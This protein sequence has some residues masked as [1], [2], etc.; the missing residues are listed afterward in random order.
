LSQNSEPEPGVW[1]LRT[2]GPTRAGR[3]SR[4]EVRNEIR[5][6]RGQGGVVL[7]LYARQFEGKALGDNDFVVSADYAE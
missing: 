4:D 1:L 2:S 3:Q 5:P 7:D 6:L